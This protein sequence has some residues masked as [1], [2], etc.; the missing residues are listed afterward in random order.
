ML[1]LGVRRKFYA[2]ETLKQVSPSCSSSAL[3]SPDFSSSGRRAAGGMKR[4]HKK[5]VETGFVEVRSLPHRLASL[6]KGQKECRHQAALSRSQSDT[7]RSEWGVYSAE[8]PYPPDRPCSSAQG[9]STGQKDELHHDLDA[10]VS[11]EAPRGDPLNLPDASLDEAERRGAA[12]VER[13]Q[14]CRKAQIA[15]EARRIRD[16]EGDKLLSKVG[17][18]LAGGRPVL[19]DPPSFFGGG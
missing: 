10:R 3:V 19:F 7:E 18:E 12:P 17:E 6:G 2:T 11:S 16:E 13:D 4:R 8:P 1:V 15:Q 9:E 14:H 5:L